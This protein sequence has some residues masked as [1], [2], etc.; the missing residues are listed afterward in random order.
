M[1]DRPMGAT[2]PSSPLDQ[3]RTN[4][5]GF[6]T[7]ELCSAVF[8][9][10]RSVDEVVR[11]DL[12]V[13]C[14]RFAGG[15]LD[16]AEILFTVD[17]DRGVVEGGLA[18]GSRHRAIA[19][20]D[21]GAA[22][23]DTIRLDRPGGP[24]PPVEPD[25]RPWPAG[26]ARRPGD[27]YA[28]VRAA[29]LD[30][31][32]TTGARGVAVVH[33]GELV[34]E[35]FAGGFDL[36]VRTRGWSTGKT[37]TA[38]IVGWLAGQGE[39]DPAAPTTIP[40]WMRLG[41]PRARIRLLDLLRLSSGLAVRQFAEGTDGPLTDA[42]EYFAMY[43]RPVSVDRMVSEVDVE[44]EPGE[45]FSY[46]SIDHLAIAVALGEVFGAQLHGYLSGIV[47]PALGLRHSLLETDAE[48]VPLLCGSWYTTPADLARIG[49]L[50]LR[51]GW[52]ADRQTL[53]AEW[54]ATMLAESPAT[55]A[56]RHVGPA[57]TQHPYGASV[58]LNRDGHVGPAEDR[59]ACYALG[60]LGQTVFVLPQLD[61]VIT[62]TALEE[63]P[64]QL[65][66]LHAVRT[67]LAHCN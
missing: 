42:D 45:L 44:A 47:L 1:E 34:V 30:H 59:A 23:V 4:A 17:R 19:S 15:A 66:L 56:G 58:W 32:A 48:G 41:D 27:D 61:L 5:L 36:T 25:R 26:D 20:G 62:R 31:L 38:L 28:P 39:L 29:V 21:K 24:L 6:C 54:I 60:S 52:L 65:T 7:K 57:E 46:K 63:H 16:P 53:P 35:E 40:A 55:L 22:L 11:H 50:I 12:G 43:F 13:I 33:R 64:R 49:E 67:A 14:R 10:G 37:L 18:D 8:V 9:S 51:G 2:R 3:R